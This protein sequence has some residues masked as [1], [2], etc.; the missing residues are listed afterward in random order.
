MCAALDYV[1]QIAQEWSDAHPTSFPPIIIH[2]TDGESTDGDPEPNSI[3]LRSIRTEEGGEAL[4]FNCH[5]S[6]LQKAGVVFPAS[7]ADLPADGFAHLLFRMSSVLPDSLRAGAE[8]RHIDCHPGARGMAFNAD[9]TQMV[10]L[11]ETGTRVDD[12][13]QG[14]SEPSNRLE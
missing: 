8:A 13:D 10:M 4:L 11:I 9:S 6:E 1:S 14:G 2:I 5:L 3:A 7:E 12:R